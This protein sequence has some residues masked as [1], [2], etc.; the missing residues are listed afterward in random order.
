MLHL[1]VDVTDSASCDSN[2][3]VSFSLNGESLGSWTK[4]DDEEEMIIDVTG[5]VG[6][7]NESVSIVATAK[8]V[9]RGSNCGTCAALFKWAYIEGLGCPV[10]EEIVPEVVVVEEES[11]FAES[12][13]EA[14]DAMLNV[15]EEEVGVDVKTGEVSGL[16]LFG[17]IA[18][19]VILIS[20]IG[21]IFTILIYRRKK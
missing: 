20:I 13:K 2:S 8:D 4:A 9:E 17:K 21:V 14:V 7:G 6:D 15:S 1:Y 19:G 10:E 16:S 5:L 3:K 12:F 11:L 18:I